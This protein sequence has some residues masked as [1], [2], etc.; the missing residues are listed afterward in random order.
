MPYVPKEKSFHVTFISVKRRTHIFFFYLMPLAERPQSQ[1]HS[2][3]K[4]EM[5]GLKGG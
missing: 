5:K 4:M 2:S 3:E 1:S